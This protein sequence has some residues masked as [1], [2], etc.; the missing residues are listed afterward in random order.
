[1]GKIKKYFCPHCEQFRSTWQ[2]TNLGYCKYCG[3][4]CFD[5]EKQLVQL[6]IRG[7]DIIKA[8]KILDEQKE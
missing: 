5:T 7:S 4:T 6:L 2:T 1:M 8:L 3:T